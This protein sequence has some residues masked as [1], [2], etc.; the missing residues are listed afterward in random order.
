MSIMFG[1]SISAKQKIANSKF[2]RL[3]TT[4]F[5]HVLYIYIRSRYIQS[6][7]CACVQDSI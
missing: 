4:F 7:Q 1:T 5:L 2:N 6:G 3:H